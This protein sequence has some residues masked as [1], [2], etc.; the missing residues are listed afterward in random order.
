M[1]SHPP[2]SPEMRAVIAEAY[3][4][5]RHHP[6]PT[7]PLDACTHCCLP[8]EME[9]ELGTL[10][11]ARLT[12]EHFYSY[13]TAAKSS[14]QPAPELLYLL[15]RLL[16]LLAEGA[17]VHHSI[18]LSLDRLGR[19][20]AGSLTPDELQVLDRFA[21]AYFGDLLTNDEHPQYEDPMAILLM[22]HIGGLSLPPLLDQ[23]LATTAPAITL[24]FVETTYWKFWAKHKYTNAFAED[25]PEFQT[26]L[27]AWM[28]DPGHRSRWTEKLLSQEFLALARHHPVTGPVDF[29]LMLDTAIHHLTG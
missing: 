6:P 9:R 10:P 22:F 3:A 4:I 14:V 7:G 24:Q 1:P 18:E 25:R 27:R 26:Q 2:I 29:E 23:W 20:P 15:P 8:R 28:L 16:E 5:F 12:D 21:L 13:N 11:L 19:C 17:E